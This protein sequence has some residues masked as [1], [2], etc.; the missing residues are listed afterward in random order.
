L[1]H[2]Q[3]VIISCVLVCLIFLSGFFSI[4]ETAL[5]AVNR[6]RLRHKARQKKSHALLILKLLKRPDRLLGMI[7]IG[8]N[9][10]NIVAS[11]LATLIAMKLWG[12]KG[13]VISTAC[14]TLIILIFAEIA[15]KTFAAL[16]PDRVSRVVAWPVYIALTIFFPLVWFI[17]MITNNL[18]RLFHI[19]VGQRPM[20]QLSREELRSVVYDTGGKM[21]RHYQTM[22]LGILDLNKVTVDDVMIPRHHITGID[23]EQPWENV[24][25]QLAHTA[26]AWM[27][28]YREQINDVVGVLHVRELTGKLLGGS[29]I[30]REKLLK[31]AK[32][33]YFVPEG[34]PLNVQLSNFQQL[35]KRLALVVDEYG[36]IKG[37][38]TLEDILE[39]I[40][41]EFT[42]NVISTSKISLQAD[43]SYLV[44][45]G[46]MLRDLNR[47]TKWKFTI[48]GPRTLNGLI[49]EQLEALPK[50]GLCLLINDHP[51]EIVQVKENQ[52]KQ[53][54]IFPK[55]EQPFD[56]SL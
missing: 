56:S 6:Y 3:F 36:E 14:L 30:N 46:I 39:E 13:V 50:A 38:V 32:E 42:T 23:I 15:P 11:A 10:A 40:V 47:Y 5:M 4:A 44:D 20:E 43:G 19:N 55:L 45:G 48:N 33:P 21:S 1:S 16:Y 54:K 12:E 37:L 53:A 29:A 18:L 8:N 26:H 7:L 52:V 34:T 17:N 49:V 28:I 41:G 25:V 9:L 51:V 35:R 22:L 24:K 31:L 2:F 27:P